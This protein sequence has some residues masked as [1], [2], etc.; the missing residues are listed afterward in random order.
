MTCL[1]SV[2]V[3][4][5]ALFIH[6]VADWFRQYSFKHLNIKEKKLKYHSEVFTLG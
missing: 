5:N 4:T 1:K 2:N 6:R 3:E